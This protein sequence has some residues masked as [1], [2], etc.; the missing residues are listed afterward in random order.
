MPQH[1]EYLDSLMGGWFHQ[2]FDI[3][4]DTPQ[5]VMASYKAKMPPSDQVGLLVDVRK[6]L[7]AHPD[8]AELEENFQKTFE[9]Q[10]VQGAFGMSTREFLNT[11]E[12]SLKD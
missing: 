2:D 1:F 10:I 7:D 4:G 5:E 8:D 3:E 9:P 12:A 6:Y 11:I